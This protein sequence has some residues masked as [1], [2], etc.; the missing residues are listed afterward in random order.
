MLSLQNAEDISS[1]KQIDV[2]LDFR[3][4][5]TFVPCSWDNVIA[6][7][8]HEKSEV[9]PLEPNGINSTFIEELFFHKKAGSFK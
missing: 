8:R 4:S 3:S 5:N 9:T 1:T 2:I 6:I 7:K